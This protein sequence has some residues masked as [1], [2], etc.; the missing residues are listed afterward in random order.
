VDFIYNQVL[1]IENGGFGHTIYDFD[2][3]ALDALIIQA[4]GTQ[5]P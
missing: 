4:L 1:T 5:K 2:K 3:D